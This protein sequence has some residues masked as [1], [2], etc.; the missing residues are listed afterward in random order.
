[1]PK[2]VLFAQRS[3]FEIDFADFSVDD[4]TCAQ[5]SI[6]KLIEPCI[7][8]FVWSRAYG[9]ALPGVLVVGR[10]FWRLLGGAA[11]A[12]SAADTPPPPP[13][14]SGAYAG[15]HGGYGWAEVS[16][17]FDTFAGAETFNHSAHGW[18]AGG[19]V[20]VQQQFGRAVVGV[21]VS[22]SDLHLTDTAESTLLPG[23]F[24]QIDIDSLFM[25]ALRIG[26]ASDRWMA[27][28][29]GGYASANVDT[30]VYKS[31]AG[32]S[33]AT[34]GRES[35]WM[36]GAGLGL[37]CGRGFLLGLEYNYVHLDMGDR[38]GMLPDHKPF[39]YGGFDDDI[40]TVTLRLSYLFG[41]YVE[42]LK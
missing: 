27:Y 35:G 36:L 21:E 7:A 4:S 10:I 29:K 11:G 33:S 34:S 26:Y 39:T 14:W 20:G 5:R 13:I 9:L 38:D 22:Y 24:R 1:M 3:I 42:P 15:I 23:R 40:H 2:I 19:Q 8:P 16:Y 32:P 31:G 18:F 25:L 37:I 12:P 41:S 17:T 6:V 28:V 30:L